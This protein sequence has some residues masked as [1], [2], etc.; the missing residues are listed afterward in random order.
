MDDDEE[1]DGLFAR[2][3]QLHV[4][5]AALHTRAE[6]AERQRDDAYAALALPR[7]ERDELRAQLA[8]AHESLSDVMDSEENY[9]AIVQKVYRT[10]LNAAM[11]DVVD[12]T[13]F[14]VLAWLRAH[15]SPA[16]PEP[17]PAGGATATVDRE[18]LGRLAYEAGAKLVEEQFPELARKFKVRA[19]DDAGEDDRERHRCMA[20]AVA[21]AVLA[22]P[23]T[24]PPRIE[25][26]LHP[27]FEW[28]YI[29]RDYGWKICK[30]CGARVDFGTPP[31]APPP[32][33]DLP[34]IAAQ[35][36][37]EPDPLDELIWTPEQIRADQQKWR[38]I[39]RY[40][41]LKMRLPDP[42]PEDGPLPELP[43]APPPASGTVCSGAYHVGPLM[44]TRYDDVRLCGACKRTVRVAALAAGG[45]GAGDAIG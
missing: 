20:E 38:L 23:A 19:W 5:L 9:R 34:P 33:T 45:E 21:R 31:A 18:V 8:S 14:D 17:P 12:S 4:Q 10:L 43:V 28:H 3:N 1:L 7:T 26:C 30:T 37:G 35:A 25:I 15:L 22:A 36:V 41:S 39:H 32:A 40:V 16:A 24:E 6:A 29:E 44:H 11:P 13:E 2:I 27:Q 42:Y